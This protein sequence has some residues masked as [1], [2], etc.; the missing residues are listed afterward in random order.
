MDSP[1]GEFGMFNKMWMYENSLNIPFIVRWPKKV[2]AGV[3]NNSLVN[4]LDIAPT[5][6][7]V[8]RGNIDPGFQGR[9]LH[10][11]LEGN[12]P[13]DWRTSTL[14][15]YHGG[16]DIPAHMGVRTQRYK[17][18]HFLEMPPA[19]GTVE[20]IPYSGKGSNMVKGESWEFYDLKTDPLEQKNLYSH[21]E[22]VEP[23]RKAHLELKRLLK[24]NY[25]Q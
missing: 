3:T 17:L 16:F 19:A 10:P 13:A 15:H 9:S 25:E 18:I 2:K 21:P 4:M 1:F 6:V 24:Q 5:F 14:Y 12:T 20:P 22:Y 8:A 7:D 11:L 23:I